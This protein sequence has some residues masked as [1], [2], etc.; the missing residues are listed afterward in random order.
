MTCCKLILTMLPLLEM[1][2][3][4]E[5][6]LFGKHSIFIYFTYISGGLLSIVTLKII[7]INS[8]DIVKISALG[9]FL[10]SYGIFMVSVGSLSK[11]NMSNF[12]K[13]LTL[14]LVLWVN[15][16]LCTSPVIW[17]LN[18]Y[19]INHYLA[20][21]CVRYFLVIRGLHHWYI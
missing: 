21:Q 10:L 6:S 12:T 3:F 15:I 18:F 20:Y 16:G 13:L 8:A 1:P 9:G 4:T 17:R 14:F 5:I 11:T 2:K 19:L 7:S